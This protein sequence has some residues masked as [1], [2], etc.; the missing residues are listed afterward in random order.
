MLLTRAGTTI[1]EA[2]TSRLFQVPVLG[3]AARRIVYDID[4]APAFSPDGAR[5]AF[6]RGGPSETAIML[7]NADGGGVRELAKRA[8]PLTFQLGL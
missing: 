3:G 2:R 4:S 6:V 8:E 5:F 7:E 1:H